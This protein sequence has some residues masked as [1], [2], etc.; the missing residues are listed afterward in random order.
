[1]HKTKKAI[2][3]ILAVTLLTAGTFLYAVAGY[4]DSA[5]GGHVCDHGFYTY[6]DRK[7]T[8]GVK[9]RYYFTDPA[10]VKTQA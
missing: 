9:G 2:S 10:L 7:L 3:V 4:F 5:A 8:G 1:M 6:G